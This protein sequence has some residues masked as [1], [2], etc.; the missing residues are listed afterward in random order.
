MIEHVAKNVTVK[1]DVSVWVALQ[2]L[3]AALT[4][5]T[6]QLNVGSLRIA[7]NDA[8]MQSDTAGKEDA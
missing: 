7:T 3:W 6:V 8:A 1:L 4:R 5:K 2:F